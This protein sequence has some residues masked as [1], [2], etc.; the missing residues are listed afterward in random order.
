MNNG[1]DNKEPYLKNVSKRSS[2][3]IKK[4]TKKLEESMI[5]S[6]HIT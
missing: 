5:K 4:T 6:W 2:K 3:V 1:S